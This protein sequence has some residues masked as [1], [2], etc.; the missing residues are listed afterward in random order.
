LLPVS[1]KG[2]PL[3]QKG[4]GSLTMKESGQQEVSVGV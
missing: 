2:R 3:W 1:H 4:P